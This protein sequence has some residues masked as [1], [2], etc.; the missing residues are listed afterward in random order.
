MGPEPLQI[1]RVGHD[2]H[3]VGGYDLGPLG[4]IGAVLLQLGVDGVKIRHRVP[5][6]AAGHVYHMDQQAAAVNVP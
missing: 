3:L 1:F 5:A 2:V 6:L 4:E